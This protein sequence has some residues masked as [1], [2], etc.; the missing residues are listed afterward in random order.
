[1]L[2]L[3][4]IIQKTK[5]GI[6]MRAVSWDKNIVPLM[7]VSVDRIIAITFLLGS[8]LGGAA[9]V[10]YAL[11]YPVIDPY[12]GIIVGWKAFI[13]AV[14]GGIGDVRGAMLGGFILG[15]IEIFSVTFLPSSFRDLIT[16]ALLL[17]LLL[18]RPYGILGH[19]KSQKL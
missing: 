14:I 7:G 2:L 15:A 5:I 13:A 6:A 16:F 3:N 17:L 8:S 11:S 19:P 12:M 10:M 4:F 18:V 1:M 9:G